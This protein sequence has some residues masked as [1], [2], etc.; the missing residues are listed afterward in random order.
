MITDSE[1]PYDMRPSVFSVDDNEGEH[2]DDTSYSQEQRDVR[3]G[4]TSRRVSQSAMDD[5][6]IE[7]TKVFENAMQSLRAIP[8]ISTAPGQKVNASRAPSHH[9]HTSIPMHNCKSIR[10]SLHVKMRAHSAC[11]AP[12]YPA[13][14]LSLP[15]VN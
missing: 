4:D 10:A 11:N 6:A 2:T 9:Q 15:L 7:R 5:E 3:E 8:S 1:E 14:L 12:L 13:S